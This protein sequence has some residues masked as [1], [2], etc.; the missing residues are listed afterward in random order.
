MNRKLVCRAGGILLALTFAAGAAAQTY[1]NYSKTMAAG[2]TSAAR[3][4]CER[5]RRLFVAWAG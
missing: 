4:L 1:G 2:K 5:Q 3:P